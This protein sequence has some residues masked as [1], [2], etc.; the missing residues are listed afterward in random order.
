MILLRR[1]QQK[2]HNLKAY[3]LIKEQQQITLKL[4]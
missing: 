1:N 2:V 4:V 3:T